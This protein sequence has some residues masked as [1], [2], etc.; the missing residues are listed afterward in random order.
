MAAAL[1]LLAHIIGPTDGKLRVMQSDVEGHSGLLQME[2]CLQ[3]T[4]F[5]RYSLS[6]GP[7]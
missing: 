4:N 5:D 7:R 2:I 3:H 1:S 6:G